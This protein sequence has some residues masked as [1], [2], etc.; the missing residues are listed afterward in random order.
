M[1]KDVNHIFF[2]NLPRLKSGFLAYFHD[3]F[4]TFEYP[5]DWLSE[6]RERNE[7]YLIRAFLQ[8]NA[9]FQI[10]LFADYLGKTQKD[11]LAENMPLCLSNTGGSLWLLK[12]I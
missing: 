3:I 7:S 9:A 6:G 5:E 2:K 1:R 11:W 12:I 10:L 4:F 8:Y